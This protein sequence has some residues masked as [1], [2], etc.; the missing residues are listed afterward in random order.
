[1]SGGGEFPG[2]DR[3]EWVRAFL[4]LEFQ[5]PF[6]LTVDHVLRLR[7]NLRQAARQGADLAP[8]AFALLFDPPVSTDPFAQRRYQL[9][10]PPFVIHPPSGLPRH[11]AIG[12]Q[13]EVPVILLGRGAHLLKAFC[14]AWQALG[15]RGLHRGEGRFE[16]VA[17][18]AEDL[19]GNRAPIWRAERSA[20]LPLVL[21]RADW[22]LDGLP[23]VTELSLSFSTPARLLSNGRPL[24]RPTFETLFPFVLRRVTSMVHAHCDVELIADPA[25]LLAAAR[26]VVVVDNG[27]RWHDWRSLEGE[28]QRQ[29][30]GGVVGR[31]VVSG[32]GLPEILWVLQFGSLLNLGKGAA[33]GAGHLAFSAIG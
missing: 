9:P 3:I 14:R 11:L 31:L 24:F 21:I 7:R 16:L 25:P 26:Q 15:A 1:M 27:L 19:A 13:L 20:S 32:D 29:D 23:Q 18:D 12:E 8:A 30:L 17:V 2:G 22:W 10:G 6:F 4:L 5:E 33:F 28:K